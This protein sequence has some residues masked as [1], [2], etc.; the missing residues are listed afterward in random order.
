VKAKDIAII[1]PYRGQIRKIREMMQKKFSLRHHLKWK[2][3][4]VGSTE[5][6]QVQF[7]FLRTNE[8]QVAYNNA[9]SHG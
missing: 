1:S 6:L 9:F 5:E 4:T 2:D 3:V 8:F 7:C